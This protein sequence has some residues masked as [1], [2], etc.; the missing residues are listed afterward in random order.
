VQALEPDTLATIVYTSGTTGRSKG[1]KLSHGNVLCNVEAS[2]AVIAIH[3]TDTTL[4]VLPMSHMF[5]RTCGYYLMLR[6]GACVAFARGIQQL[7]DDLASVQP[8][9]LIAVPRLFERF[10]ARIEQTLSGSALK[11]TL[12]HAT[13]RYGWKV[14]LGEA[15]L[16]ERLAYARL[17]PLVAGPILAKLGGRLRL[18]GAG[19]AK[20]ELHIAQTFIAL[21]VHMIQGYGMT[22]AS[23]VIAANREDD[24]DPSSVGQPLDGVEYRLSET[25]ELLVRGPSVMQGYWRNPE[26][27]AQVLSAD[28]WLNTGDIVEIRDGRIYIRGRSKDIIVLSNGEKFPPEEAESALTGDPVFEQVMLIGEGR[29]FVSL[30]AVTQETD[31]KKL[32]RLANQRLTAFPRY[33]RVRRVIQTTEPWTIDNG[34]L[35]P[36]LK[37]KRPVVMQHFA[38]SIEAVYAKDDAD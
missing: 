19:G 32:V 24:N 20:L 28:G 25:S 11:R 31:E 8:T 4:S 2:A 1:V 26:A 7:G 33:V 12:F 37:V 15:N 38:H 16:F 21:G 36:T 27:T 23:P 3:D 17:K 10:L 14:F 35:T 30:V 22:E 34:M 5:E 29:H 18:A 6:A 13:I 9:L